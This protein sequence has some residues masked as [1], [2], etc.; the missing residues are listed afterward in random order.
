MQQ[1]LRVDCMPSCSR[2]VWRFQLGKLRVLSAR[3]ICQIL[4][5]HNFVKV[6]QRGSHIIMQRQ[7]VKTRLLQSNLPSWMLPILSTGMAPVVDDLVEEP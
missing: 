1:K 7:E 6:R 5:Q 3:T 4:E 2:P